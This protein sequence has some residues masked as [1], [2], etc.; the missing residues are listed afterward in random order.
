MIKIYIKEPECFKNPVIDYKLIK[1]FCKINIFN[2]TSNYMIENY[3]REFPTF[4]LISFWSDFFLQ[5][6]VKSLWS[7][8][9]FNNNKDKT[10]F[11]TEFY[12]E[13]YKKMWKYK[14]KIS[15][16]PEIIT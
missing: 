6:N 2:F 4:S 12:T 9:S 16:L 8:I 15:K 3:L 1:T 13:Y 11:F 14:N 5:K 7:F 10:H